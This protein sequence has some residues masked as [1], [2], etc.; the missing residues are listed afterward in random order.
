VLPSEH[1]FDSSLLYMSFGATREFC[2]D[3]VAKPLLPGE[4]SEYFICLCFAHAHIIGMRD[5]H[6]TLGWTPFN[7]P[8]ALNQLLEYKLLQ[9][10]H[11][12][13]YNKRVV[14]E[15]G[16]HFF[17]SWISHIKVLWL[18]RSFNVKRPPSDEQLCTLSWTHA[19]PERW[20]TGDSLSNLAGHEGW[21]PPACA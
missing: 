12:G 5:K 2:A 1:L 19:A 18:K 16:L 20:G 14:H 11:H 7:T 8:E 3:P 9:T 17:K 6:A 21:A 13:S 15:Y 4:G 10:V